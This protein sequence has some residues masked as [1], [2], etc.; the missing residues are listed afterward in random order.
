MVEYGAMGWTQIM[1]QRGEAPIG[2]EAPWF[3]IPVVSRILR[4]ALE[5]MHLFFLERFLSPQEW[6]KARQGYARSTA[7]NAIVGRAG[8]DGM[9]G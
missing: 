1:I 4:R 3:V 9:L 7:V 2:F 8:G 5:V 6:H